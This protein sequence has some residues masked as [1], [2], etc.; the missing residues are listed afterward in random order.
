MRLTPIHGRI[1]I[2]QALHPHLGDAAD[3][4]QHQAHGRVD[5]ADHQRQHDDKRELDRVDVVHADR[6]WRQKRREH[7]ERRQRFDEDPDHQHDHHHDQQEDVGIRGQA[8]RP[9][10][11]RLTKAADVQ[12]AA[13]GSPNPPRAASRRRSRS[14][15]SPSPGRAPGSTIVGMPTRDDHRHRKGDRSRLGRGVVPAEDPADDDDRNHQDRERP[16]A[17]TCQPHATRE[18]CAGG[19]SPRRRATIETTAPCRSSRPITSTTPAASI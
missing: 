14:R 10:L 5:Q 15:T 2:G 4:K 19:V 9:G 16:D 6:H 17:R 1:V 7:V 18:I 13:R 12:Q 11:N 8:G 3:K